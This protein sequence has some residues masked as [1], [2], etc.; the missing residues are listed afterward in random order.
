M[1]AQQEVVVHQLAEALLFASGMAATDAILRASLR[2]GDHLVIPDDAYGGTFRLIDKVFTQWG[3]DYSVA[4]VS[5]IDAP[6]LDRTSAPPA[7]SPWI[8]SV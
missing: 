5:D 4:P 6:G 1:S 7:T 2:P 3:I 8:C